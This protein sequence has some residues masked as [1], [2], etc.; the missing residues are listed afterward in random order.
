VFVIGS[1]RVTVLPAGAQLE[2][3]ALQP[4]PIVSYVPAGA[5]PGVPTGFGFVV[6]WKNSTPLV[7]GPVTAS[8]VSALPSTHPPL[9]E[10]SK[11]TMLAVAGA[12]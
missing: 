7:L 4:H 11:V 5:A 1:V 6:G 8:R 12:V 10:Y 9:R 3:E 2:A